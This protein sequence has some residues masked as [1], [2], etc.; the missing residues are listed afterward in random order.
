V[1]ARP[2]LDPAEVAWSLATTQSALEHRAV[3]TGGDSDELAAG[4]ASVATGATGAGVVTGRAAEDAGK[5]VF[6]FPGQG[7]Q[8]AGMGRELAESSPVFAARLAEAGQAAGLSPAA[9]VGHSQ[10][11]SR[12]RRWPGSCRWTTGRGWW[13]CAAKR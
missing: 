1:Q 4:L 6:V 11:R 8:W 12:R 7:G 13:R 2:G 9:V 3:V 5:V 10:G